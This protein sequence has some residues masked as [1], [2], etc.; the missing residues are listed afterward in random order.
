M[1][2][3]EIFREKKKLYLFIY[4]SFIIFSITT[5]VYSAKPS[6]NEVWHFPYLT[7]VNTNVTFRAN[8]TDPDNDLWNVFI[9]IE[10]CNG[11]TLYNLSMYNISQDIYEYI[12]NATCRGTNRYRIHA[13]DLTFNETF[14]NWT[15]F[16]VVKTWPESGRVLINV[17]VLA[18]CCGEIS[19]FF[20]P[21]EILQNQTTMIM[22]VFRNC[23]NIGLDYHYNYITIINSNGS[24]IASWSGPGIPAGAVDISEESFFWAIWYVDGTPLGNYT[25]I[26]E[27]EYSSTYEEGNI[28]FGNFSELNESANC[29]GII[30]SRVNC[31]KIDY[32][33]CSLY[34]TTNIIFVNTTTVS[35]ATVPG[36]NNN[37]VAYT[38]TTNID[39]SLYY[40]YTFNMSSCDEYCYAC[41]S[42]DTNLTSD[43][44]NYE[45]Y[46]ISSLEY[47]VFRVDEFGQNVTFREMTESC[48]YTITSYECYIHLNGTTEC[49]YTKYCY[50]KVRTEVPFEIV[51]QVG[52]EPTPTPSPIFGPYPVIIREM[53]PQINQEQTCDPSDP[54]NTCTYT[55]NR[56]IILNVG[57]VNASN[58]T[59]YDNATIGHCSIEN[60]SIIAYRCVNSSEY[61]CL[62]TRNGNSLNVKF[63]IFDDIPPNGYKIL[64]YELVPAFNTS[65][66]ASANISY[67]QFNA[68]ATFYD[69]SERG[70]GTM[71][72]VYENDPYYNPP[73]SKVMELRNVSAFNYELDVRSNGSIGRRDFFT[74]E[75]TLFNFTIFSITGTG[76]TNNPWTATIALP[77]RWNITSCACEDINYGCSYTD[78]ELTYTGIITPA[79]MTT[80]KCNFTAIVTT[81][82]FFL[83]PVNKTL[84][85]EYERYIPG[86]FTINRALIT[87]NITQ[88]ITQN[89]T[90]QQ[91]LPMPFPMPIER[92][93]EVEKEVQVPMEIEVPKNVTVPE[94]EMAINIEPIEREINGTQ[95]VFI[96]AIFNITNIG[97]VPVDNVTLIPIVPEGWEFKTALVSFLDVGNST[98][99]TI[100]VKP[101]YNAEGKYAIPVK[102]VRGNLTM[103]ID[104]FWLNIIKEVNISVLEILEYPSVIYI[105]VNSNATVPILLRN[106]GKIRLHDITGRLENAELCIDHYSFS[107]IKF[108]D[109]E[110]IKTSHLSIRAKGKPN[111]C[112]TTMIFGSRE[113]AYA[114]AD[115]T[116]VV[117]PPPSL[118][119]P[120]T[121]LN[122]L[123]VLLIFIAILMASRSGGER[124]EERRMTRG[125][126]AIRII[127]Y[128]I[129]SIIIFVMIYI[130]FSIFGFPE[131]NIRI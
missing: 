33:Y 104:Y 43:E 69:M 37:T 16:F 23:G 91:P 95:G 28:T 131:F 88:N 30:N 29:S 106:I 20:I 40:A 65:A 107:S 78:T 7:E 31:T 74:T 83:L 18:R 82:G 22:M 116:I 14:S 86:L 34:P 120:I 24:E 67:Y 36:M 63:E 49:N 51:K 118:I 53:P 93:K 79:T 126:K 77:Y 73:E 115:V 19:Y 96:P 9:D 68:S 5:L 71:Y 124:V 10:L 81:E 25:A 108:L 2:L 35:N 90:I 39:G 50:G 75:E 114:F 6:I 94:L 110:Q 127:L 123:L 130:L 12:F 102:A 44:C 84:D 55:E 62:I 103:D 113:E 13:I 97:N 21:K 3:G 92:E 105:Q 38:G 85:G 122:M 87:R 76:Q 66:Y 100:F 11:T 70:N 46:V 125:Q 47:E 89:I 121:K 1:N 4:I 80:V 59:V 109:P 129:V 61:N 99:R 60:C 26:G 58:V 98:N 72:R 27:V 17:Y 64:E 15:D 42:N 111:R 117:M 8:V 119:P 57:I 52:V 54:W 32:M 45:D 41:L 128:F 48:D 56:L 101:P 112:K